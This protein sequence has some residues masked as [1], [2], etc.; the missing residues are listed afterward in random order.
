MGTL[1]L[2]P[3]DMVTNPIVLTELFHLNAILL[4]PLPVTLIFVSIA[5]LVSSGGHYQTLKPE[6]LGS[7]FAP[8]AR[9]RW[10]DERTAY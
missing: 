1:I 3:S 8:K 4:A 6:F 10:G 9:K 5:F 7:G 2:M